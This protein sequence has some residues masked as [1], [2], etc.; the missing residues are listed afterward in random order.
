LPKLQNFGGGEL[1]PPPSPAVHSCFLF[2]QASDQISGP[3]SLG[4]SVNKRDVAGHRP[5]C[6]SCHVFSLFSSY[7]SFCK[8]CIGCNHSLA[9]HCVCTTTTAHESTRTADPS[10]HSGNNAHA[11]ESRSY[12]RITQELHMAPHTSIH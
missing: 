5:M 1:D 12:V 4:T 11:T 9:I 7:S 8:G 2:T 6:P 10:C 3:V